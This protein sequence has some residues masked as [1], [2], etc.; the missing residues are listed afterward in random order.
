[1]ASEASADGRIDS[2]R[3]AEHAPQPQPSSGGW[4]V[5]R[6]AAHSDAPAQ[7]SAPVYAPAAQK[8]RD[9]AR[10]GSEKAPEQVPAP[11]QSP[12]PTPAPAQVSHSAAAPNADLV[13]QRWV[14]VVERLATH[15]RVVWSLLSQNGQLGA[16]D[17]DQLVILFPS[18]GMVASFTNGE[19][20]QIVEDT[21]YDV[22]GVRLHVSAQVGQSGG[23]PA[24]SMPTPA[25]LLY[26]A[27]Q[28]RPQLLR[29][30]ML[31]N[32]SPL[33]SATQTLRR[34]KQHQHRNSTFRRNR[35]MPQ[36]PMIRRHQNLTI[37]I[38]RRRPLLIRGIRLKR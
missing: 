13:R 4:E 30:H 37:G 6:P 19:R 21:I 17:G 1:M 35:S 12:A 7:H 27:H 15:S 9:A 5:T 18:Q 34:T 22:L 24:V 20:A 8:P 23:G 25:R 28:R 10:E 31:K 14:D 38:L 2:P 11:S 36:N 16:V 33:G 3:Q 26:R 29:L 32:R